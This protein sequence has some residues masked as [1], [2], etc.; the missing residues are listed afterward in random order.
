MKTNDNWKQYHIK[1]NDV[2][3]HKHTHTTVWVGLGEA[4][5]WQCETW[6][7]YT[8]V[9]INQP[10]TVGEELPLIGTTLPVCHTIGTTLLKKQFRLHFWNT[11]FEQVS[12]SHI[13]AKKLLPQASFWETVNCNEQNDLEK[14][15]W[16][17]WI[18]RPYQ[19]NSFECDVATW[20][21]DP[22]YPEM[23]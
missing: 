19:S 8:P 16:V 21:R 15:H 6:G 23:W 2:L 12:V 13:L 18:F 17:T 4:P 3:K 5:S 22:L 10:G 11:Q 1:F 14:L 9:F 20:G 7:G